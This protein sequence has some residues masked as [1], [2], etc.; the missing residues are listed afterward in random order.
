MICVQIREADFLYFGVLQ[1]I[2]RTRGALQARAKDEHSHYRSFSRIFGLD[3]LLQFTGVNLLASPR[4]HMSNVI[5]KFNRE[6]RQ[7]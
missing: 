1:Q 5:A 3:S 6:S 7:T 2:I 4:D